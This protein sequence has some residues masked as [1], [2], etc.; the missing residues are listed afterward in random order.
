MK[1]DVLLSAYF[2]LF[3]ILVTLSG[4]AT[5]G[6]QQFYRQTA[7]SKYDPVKNVFVFQ[8]S[9]VD[10]NEIYNLLFPDF[11][12]IG[13]SSFNGPLEDP[14]SS[15]DY[16]KS[17]GTDVFVVTAQFA[18][19]RTSFVPLVTPTT[20]TTTISGV[21]GRGNFYGT[22]TS[23]GTSMTPVPITVH[24]YDQH[25][26]YLKN[27]NKIIPLWEKTKNDYK[28]TGDNKLQGFWTNETY[29]LDIYLSGSQL[30]GFVTKLKEDRPEWKIGDLK[31]IFNPDTGAGIFLWGDKT[32][33]P[34]T[35]TLNKFGHLDVKIIDINQR[36]SFGRK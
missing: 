20:S 35:I 16:A 32:P 34:S 4:C 23:F 13:E 18:E 21:S 7:P 28:K 30:V 12:I 36:L 22:A 11:L 8:Y 5:Y 24:R 10:I 6:Y 27:V 19:T 26:V 1:R 14:R 3:V 17:I 31:M 15:I 25:G 33:R 2:V 29:E 9:N